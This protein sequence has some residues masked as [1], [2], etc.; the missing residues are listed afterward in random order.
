MLLMK[1]D[2]FLFLF[3]IFYEPVK[4]VEA[5]KRLTRVKIRKERKAGGGWGGGGKRQVTL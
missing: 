1:D 4:T 3:F 5:G 2:G